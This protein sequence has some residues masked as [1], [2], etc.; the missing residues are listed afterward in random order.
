MATLWVMTNGATEVWGPLATL[1]R[2]RWPAAL[3]RGSDLPQVW[4]SRQMSCVDSSCHQAESSYASCLRSSRDRNHG[5]QLNGSF[6]APEKIRL[7]R[8]NLLNTWL[9]LVN[10]DFPALE[11]LELEY[12]NVW[13][14]QNMIPFR[15]LKTIHISRCHLYGCLEICAPNLNLCL[16]STHHLVILEGLL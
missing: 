11:H 16:S 4:F 5:S 14:T 10:S 9:M 1:A 13:S 12:C 3:G 6:S 8:V 15:S 2:Q 7:E